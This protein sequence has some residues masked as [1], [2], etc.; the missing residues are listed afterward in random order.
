MAQTKK[1]SSSTKTPAKPQ[2]RPSHTGFAINDTIKKI[3]DRK[4]MLQDL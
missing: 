3:K 4:K 2:K 1:S